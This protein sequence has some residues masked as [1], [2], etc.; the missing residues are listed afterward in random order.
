VKVICQICA[1]EIGDTHL[2]DLRYPM[3]GAMFTTLDPVHGMPPPFDASLDWENFRCP[4]GRMHR[5]MVADNQV[6]TDEGI[7]VLPRDGGQAYID[8]RANTEVG[9]DS[10]ADRMIQ[11]SD[12]DAERI[13]RETIKQESGNGKAEE[14]QREPEDD[15]PGEGKA[16]T[17]CPECGKGFENELNMKRHQKM[18]HRAK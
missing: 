14:E 7:V 11:V 8:P 1:E 9:R 4:Y 5:P 16:E 15:Q 12:E 17:P 10:I 3:S 6:L 18:A 2:R 13:A